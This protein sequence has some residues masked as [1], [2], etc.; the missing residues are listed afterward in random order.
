MD[1]K[2]PMQVRHSTPAARDRWTEPV[3]AA[4]VVCAFSLA[5]LEQTRRCLSEVRRGKRLPK[6]L[7]VVVD[8]NPE[9]L[10]RLR[11]TESRDAIV[12]ENAGRGLSAGRNTGLRMASTEVVVFLDDDAWPEEGWLEA[13]LDPFG[14]PAVIGVGGHAT[15]DWEDP[16]RA[17]P[18]ELYW[19]VGSTYRGHRAD[20]GPISRPIGVSMA[21]RREALLQLGGFSSDFGRSGKTGSNEE[22]A[23]FSEVAR[24][25]GEDRVWFA[26]AAKVHH[27]AP[28][29]R[30][31]TPYLLRRSAMEGRSKAEIRT[32]YG[33]SAMAHDRSY[34][35]N[36]IGRAVLRYGL[37]A[38]CRVD[39]CAL[40]HC[41]QVLGC[42]IV[43]AAAYSYYRAQAVL[44][45]L[46]QLQV[47]A[48]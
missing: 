27:F 4:V 11:E 6:E 18:P 33:K 21:V 24:H 23:M 25:F 9:L 45:G 20:A 40:R 38:C 47:A 26:P 12:L 29:S 35:R 30:C 3:S 22:L 17:L 19:V 48:R 10:R 37:L 39:R 13:M 42:F 2:T 31:S 44:R 34:V 43:T 15:P 28:A 36:I 1:T 7:I 8:N 5:R 46:L 16:S 14:N 32:R 41:F